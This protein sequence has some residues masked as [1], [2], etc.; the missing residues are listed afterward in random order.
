MKPTDQALNVISLLRELCRTEMTAAILDARRIELEPSR[1]ALHP[2][3]PTP[4]YLG[5]QVR[6][7]KDH[8]S[9]IANVLSVE[10]DK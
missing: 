8:A 4:H 6:L 5:E 10:I 7:L 1:A 9:G 2:S 3:P